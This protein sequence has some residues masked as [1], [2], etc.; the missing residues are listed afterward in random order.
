MSSQNT[1]FYIKDCT[2]S[3]LATGIKA[4]TLC[5][6][7]DR[8]TNISLNVIYYHFWGG[9]LRTAFEYQEYHNDFSNWAHR[10]LHDD[11]LG[12]RFDL[13][14][15]RE[16]G[17]ME[18]LRTDMI[19]MIDNRL[20]EIN[21][22][23]TAKRDEIFHFME[24][25]IIV[26]NTRYQVDKPSDLVRILPLMTRSSYYYHFIDSGRRVSE[27]SNDFSVWLKGLGEEKYKELIDQLGQIDPYLISLTM[28]QQNQNCQ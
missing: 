18:L 12:E 3:A 13:I 4:E 2:L 6:L 21:Y 14:S 22:I 11:I 15:P 26:F 9:R 24:S 23:P 10:C 28:L 16:Y 17:D 5:Q 1:P 19:E 27:K 7:R 20:D 8:L 25:T